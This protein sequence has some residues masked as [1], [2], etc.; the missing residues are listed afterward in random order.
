[1]IISKYILVLY[2]FDSIEVCLRP[3]LSYRFIKRHETGGRKQASMLLDMSEWSDTK[4]NVKL[5]GF[6]S[7][8]Q[9]SYV[10]IHT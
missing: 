4:S 7:E 10:S 3:Q 8:L 2:I 9:A 5:G 1:M 6:P